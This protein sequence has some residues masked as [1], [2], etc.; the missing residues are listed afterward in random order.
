MA[1]DFKAAAA[2]ASAHFE[3]FTDAEREKWQAKD[4]RAHHE[5]HER[6]KAAYALDQCYLCQKDFKTLSRDEPCLHWLLRRGKFKNKDIVLI[7]SKYG[8]RQISAYLRWC[9]NS[10]RVLA[11]IND[12]VEEAPEGKVLS[13][14][15]RWKNIEWSFDCSTNDFAGHNGAHT[16]FPHYHFQMR[17]DGRQFI[18]FND[19][20]LPFSDSDLFFF[21][22]ERQQ[23]I[24]MDYG[25]HGAGMQAAMQ[26]DPNDLVDSLSPTDNVEDAA[27]GLS[28]MVMAHDKPM[29]GEDIYD[30]IQESKATGRSIASILHEKYAGTDVAVQTIISPSD[31]VPPITP[32][33][34]HTRR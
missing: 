34:E 10:E 27:F 1:I 15:I 33:T 30:A 13:S 29:K 28:T 31:T 19:Y 11:N 20:H 5:Q 14:T 25:T 26:F 17:I 21:E 32:R 6:F 9:A 16:N 7:A 23:G 3:R 2:R 12:L 24:N 8:Y 22:L 4:D 18:N